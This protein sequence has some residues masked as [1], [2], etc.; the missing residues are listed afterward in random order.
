PER[1]GKGRGARSEARLNQ[2]ISD[3]R[4]E[5]LRRAGHGSGS[6]IEGQ[7]SVADLVLAEA[8][9]HRSADGNVARRRRYSKGEVGTRERAFEDAGIADGSIRRRSMGR[10]PHYHV[11]REF[12]SAA[13]EDVVIMWRAAKSK[14]LQGLE[15]APIS[16]PW[17][18][19]IVFA[20]R[21]V[22]AE[23]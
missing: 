1:G 14:I 16:V 9:G 8:A 23:L 21:G 15:P 10:C 6:K 19:H 2:L 20:D 12:Y 22:P 5:G 4:P 13:P 11:K 3:I 7:P 18:E 17:C